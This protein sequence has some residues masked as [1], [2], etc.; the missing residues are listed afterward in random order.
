[1]ERGMAESLGLCFVDSDLDTQVYS[2]CEKLC[3][4]LNV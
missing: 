2:V 3:N 4:F 1:M